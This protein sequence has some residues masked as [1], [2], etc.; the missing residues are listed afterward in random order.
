VSAG[1]VLPGLTGRVLVAVDCADP[2]GLAQFWRH[3]LGGSATA[4][5]GVVRLRA[6]ALSLDFL[7]VPDAKAGKNRWHLDLASSDQAAAVEAALALGATRADD[8][9]AGGSWQVLR[10]PEGN[11][12]CI[13]DPAG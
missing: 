2:V 10:D 12:F 6:G 8:I 3:L 7:P 4:G 13:L 11:E 1:H 5:D 9:F